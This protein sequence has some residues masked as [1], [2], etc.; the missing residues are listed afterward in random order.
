M[1]HILL[2]SIKLYSNLISLCHASMDCMVITTFVLLQLLSDHINNVASP[3]DV[4]QILYISH[5][6]TDIWKALHCYLSK[7][8]YSVLSC[9][10]FSFEECENKTVFF[11][12]VFCIR[13]YAHW[14]CTNTLVGCCKHAVCKLQFISPLPYR[15]CIR[16]FAIAQAIINFTIPKVKLSFCNCFITIFLE[17]HSSSY[18]LHYRIKNLAS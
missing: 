12:N 15:N 17:F 9:L 10:L 8:S 14:H 11:W 3:L 7:Y 6:C 16:A 13:F 4:T 5:S 2:N 1:F 18:H